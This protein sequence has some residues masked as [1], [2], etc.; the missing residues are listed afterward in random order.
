M[1]PI[2]TNKKTVITLPEQQQQQQQQQIVKTKQEEID[3]NEKVEVIEEKTKPVMS[4]KPTKKRMIKNVNEVHK[5][6][7]KK[8]KIDKKKSKFLID[9]KEN[10]LKIKR[11]NCNVNK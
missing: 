7:L 3:D 6:L 5:F 9:L 8:K 1:G 2:K 11:I 4:L 10:D